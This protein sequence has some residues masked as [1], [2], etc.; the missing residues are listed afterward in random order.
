MMVSGI[1]EVSPF[2]EEFRAFEKAEQLRPAPRQGVLFYGSSTIRLWS[3]LRADFPGLRLVNR[4]FGGS[5]LRECVE[6]MDRL[7][8]PLDPQAVVLY[9]GDNDLDA[10]VTPEDLASIF[11]RFL[12]RFRETLGARPLVFVSIKPSPIRCWNIVNIRRSN[13]LLREELR[14]REP[15][16]FVDVYP[17]ML[18]LA[19]RPRRELFVEDGLHM[20]AAGYALWTPFVRRALDELGIV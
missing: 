5:T 12:R 14:Q 19:G 8:F 10:R 6:E 3:S 7:V 2:E 15:A 9:A 4:G 16:R 11:R 13:A 20:N 18:D 17:L 1:K